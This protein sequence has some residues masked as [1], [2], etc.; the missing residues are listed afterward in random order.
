MKATQSVPSD[1]KHERFIFSSDAKQFQ[2]KMRKQ[3]YRTKYHAHLGIAFPVH[4]V[5]YWK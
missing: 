4:F 3:G 5:T 1:A 2:R